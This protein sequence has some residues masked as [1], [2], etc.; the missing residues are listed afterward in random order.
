M[1][2][3]D[4]PPVSAVSS[5]ITAAFVKLFLGFFCCCLILGLYALVPYYLELRGTSELFFGIAAGMHGLGGVVGMLIFGGAADRR[6]RRASSLRYFAPTLVATALALPAMSWHPLW[7]GVCLGLQGVTGGIGL[8]IMF[9]WAS[10][11]CPPSRRTEAFAW[12]GIAGLAA[13]SLGPLLGE[14]LLLTQGT[15]RAPADFQLVFAAALVLAPLVVL[16]L[17]STP[18]VQPATDPS[19][20]ALRVWPLLQRRAVRTTLLA[21]VPFGGALGIVLSLGKNFVAS[22]DLQLVSVLLS[23]HT[24]GAIGSRLAM[25]WFLRRFERMQLIAASFFGV[26]LSMLQLAITDGYGLLLTA[27]LT[28]GV[29]HGILFPTL[30]SRLIDYGG[31]A[32]AGRLTTLYMGMFSLGAGA[33][34]AGAGVVLQVAGYSTVFVSVAL[35]CL[36]GLSLTRRAEAQHAS[37]SAA[38]A[39][40]RG[41]SSP[42]TPK[43]RTS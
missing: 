40:D 16:F 37:A 11:L 34:T 36:V 42:T 27:G 12:L 13:D 31:T 8:P 6:T 1:T 2:S 35:I 15:T 39:S 9:V 7:Y 21:V 28:Y 4:A 38:E 43:P 24:V 18:D 22:I 3:V 32:A 17:I 30:L 26:V 5:L 29:S 23:G 20:G 19:A 10:E 41:S 14:T 33:V 25:P